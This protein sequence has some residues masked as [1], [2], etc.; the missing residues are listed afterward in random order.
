MHNLADGLRVDLDR[1]GEVKRQDLE[2]QERYSEAALDFQLKKEQIDAN[3][4]VQVHMA[5]A[6]GL[7]DTADN[8]VADTVERGMAELAGGV[9]GA[10]TSGMSGRS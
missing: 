3:K 8:F 5:E 7:L 1:V 6:V 9:D 4:E 2:N 10:R